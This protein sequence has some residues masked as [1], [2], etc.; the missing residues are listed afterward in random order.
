[1]SL[2]S[3]SMAKLN[4][5]DEPLIE[6]RNAVLKKHGKIYGALKEE[7]NRALSE[8]AKK[9]LEECTST[10]GCKGEF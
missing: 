7:V 3:F 1:M 10:G 8:R 4:C 2:Y 6:L 9:I 5:D